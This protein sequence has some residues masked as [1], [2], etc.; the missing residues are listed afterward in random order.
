M[1][2]FTRRD[3]VA[4]AGLGIVGVAGAAA[5]TAANTILPNYSQVINSYLGVEQGWDNSGVNTDGL[6]L[7]YNKADYTREEIAEPE[8]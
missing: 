8:R 1:A 4:T 7:Q 6:D 2:N 5:A 3:V